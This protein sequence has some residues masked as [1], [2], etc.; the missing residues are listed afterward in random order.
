MLVVVDLWLKVKQRFLMGTEKII[1]LGLSSGQNASVLDRFILDKEE[2]SLEL[3]MPFTV[4]T[5][6]PFDG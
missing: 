2:S 5:K 4:I 3:P 1:C 6:D